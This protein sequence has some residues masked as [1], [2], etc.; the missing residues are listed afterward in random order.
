M[1]KSFA[2]YANPQ[3]LARQSHG[4]RVCMKEDDTELQRWAPRPVRFDQYIRR[5]EAGREA[6]GVDGAPA[7]AN[8]ER[9]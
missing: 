7:A 5:I 3:P 2:C 9:H 8:A 4:M 1:G 6:V